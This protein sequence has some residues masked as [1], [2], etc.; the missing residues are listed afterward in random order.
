MNR[1]WLS[2]G[3]REKNIAQHDLSTPT[4]VLRYK[5]RRPVRVCLHKER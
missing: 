2:E 3:K 1:M 5:P 4:L